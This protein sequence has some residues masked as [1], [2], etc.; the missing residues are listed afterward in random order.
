[1]H[2]NYDE[3]STSQVRDSSI[4]CSLLDVIRSHIHYIVLASLLLGS[5][6]QKVLALLLLHPEQHYHV[7][8]IARLTS[9]SAGTLHKELARLAQAGVLRREKVGNQVRY[10][11]NRQC[12][13]FPEL[14]GILRK[15]AGLADVLKEALAG[16]SE[17]IALALVFGS[18]A[19]GE[20]GPRSDVDVLLVGEIG[21]AEAVAAMH[22]AQERIGREINPVVLSPSEFRNKAVNG[23]TFLA[24]VLNN[25]KL[26]L[27]G[28]EHDLGKLAGDQTITAA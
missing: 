23:D 15:T 1:V 9:T 17:R 2:D 19:R 18:V 26:Y 8:E 4:E 11:A 21:F 27:L 3:E 13:I 10:G 6:R 22:A 7:R 28:D 20:E 5:Y 14:A 12:P 25:E 24:Q 16:Q